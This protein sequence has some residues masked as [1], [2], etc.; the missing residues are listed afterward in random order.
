VRYANYTKEWMFN[1]NF[2]V[3]LLIFTFGMRT[4][5]VCDSILRKLRAPGETGYKIPQGDMFNYLTAANLW[6]EAIEWLGWS[7]ACW[8]LQSFAFAFFA[9]LYLSGRSYSHHIWYKRK[10]DNYPN[11]R[12]IF[13]PFLI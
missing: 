9:C 7:I 12:K 3:G 5:I 10:F 2:L 8:S 13:I 6:G 4:N 11:Q 1:W